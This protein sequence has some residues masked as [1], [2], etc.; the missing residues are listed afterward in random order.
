MA[1][2]VA[3]AYSA[4]KALNS[5]F[6]LFVSFDMACVLG[7][8]PSPHTERYAGLSRAQRNKTSPCYRGILPATP[9]IRTSSFTMESRLLRPLPAK[10]A[11]MVAT[12]S[13]RGLHSR[14]V[15]LEM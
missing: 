4:A 2:R 9:R 10:V 3:D 6:K 14:K 1:A 5:K 8:L 11:P 15:W 12:S 7:K 13:R